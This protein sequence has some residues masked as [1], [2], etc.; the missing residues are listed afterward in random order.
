[1]EWTPWTRGG[2]R[3]KRVRENSTDF[4]ASVVIVVVIVVDFL[5]CNAVAIHIPIAN[6]LANN[7]S[8]VIHISLQSLGFNKLVV[9]H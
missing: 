2:T 7:C 9:H 6:D 8:W 3:L 4:L 1:M 5:T